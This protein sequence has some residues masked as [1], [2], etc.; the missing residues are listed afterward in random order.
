MIKICLLLFACSKTYEY[1]ARVLCAHCTDATPKIGQFYI[2]FVRNTTS[3]NGE[4]P[5]KHENG[6]NARE[7]LAL[8]THN[9]HNTGDRRNTS[10]PGV[11]LCVTHALTLIVWQR[12]LKFSLLDTIKSAI[13]NAR[14]YVQQRPG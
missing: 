12:K 5:L 14:V 1:D 10:I 2:T 6:T 4:L 11:I 7:T 8:T 13:S 3:N 9:T